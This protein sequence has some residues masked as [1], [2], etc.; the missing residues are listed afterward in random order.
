MIEIRVRYSKE[1]GPIA[2][3]EYNVNLL[4]ARV[5]GSEL[6]LQ[7]ELFGVPKQEEKN[8]DNQEEATG[9]VGRKSRS[10]SGR[11]DSASS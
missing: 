4:G 11:S 9:D 8:G 7:V 10:R 3:G 6:Y 1:E 2:D 5:E